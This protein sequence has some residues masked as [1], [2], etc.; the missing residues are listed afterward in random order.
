MAFIALVP[1]RIPACQR[2]LCMKNAV[3]SAY[4]F[5]GLEGHVSEYLGLYCMDHARKKVESNGASTFEL[6]CE[7]GHRVGRTSR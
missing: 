6:A 1:E 3:Y 5:C 4:L 7:R 2:T